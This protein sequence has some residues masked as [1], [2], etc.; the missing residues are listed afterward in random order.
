MYQREQQGSGQ[1]ALKTLTGDV[2]GT[3]ERLEKK[4]EQNVA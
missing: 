4:A 3:A 1:E 2:V